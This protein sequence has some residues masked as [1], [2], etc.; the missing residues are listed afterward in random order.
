M[1]RLGLEAQNGFG[2]MNSGRQ[3]TG[4]VYEICLLV[5]IWNV[6]VDVAW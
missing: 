2:G 4:L 5:Q 3:R 6:G 1:D